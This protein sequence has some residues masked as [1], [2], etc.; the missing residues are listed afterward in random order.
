[1]AR[2][3]DL[4]LKIL[5]EDEVKILSLGLQKLFG[6]EIYAQMKAHGIDPGTTVR[7]MAVAS[8]CQHTREAKGL[9]IKAAAAE[10]KIPQYRLKDIE[11]GQVKNIKSEIL[12]RYIAFLGL[13]R[14]FSQW[15]KAN[16]TLAERIL[17]DS[18]TTNS[19]INGQGKS[20]AKRRKSQV[21]R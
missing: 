14:W 8:R 13:S 6:P 11:Q 17:H 19:L 21:G 16:P 12:L 3:V 5:T 7:F 1:M 18:D 10:M 15:K 4:R 20:K 2:K 9:S